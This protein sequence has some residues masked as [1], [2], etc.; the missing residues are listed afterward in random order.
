MCVTTA[1]CRI[2]CILQNQ[3]KTA[4]LPPTAPLLKDTSKDRNIN[5]SDIQRYFRASWCKSGK[6]YHRKYSK[7]SDLFVSYPKQ[8]FIRTEMQKNKYIPMSVIINDINF[9]CNYSHKIFADAKKYV[10]T[11]FCI[12]VQFGELFTF[13]CPKTI[14]RHHT[15]FQLFCCMPKFLQCHLKR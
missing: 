8:Q 10:S 4:V 2:L 14:C 11:F 7:E 5:I 9:V 15:K 3:G 12:T 6:F 13:F 1:T